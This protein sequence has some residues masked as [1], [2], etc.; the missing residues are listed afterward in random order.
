MNTVPQGSKGLVSIQAYDI[1][2]HSD[3]KV[4]RYVTIVEFIPVPNWL[5]SGTAPA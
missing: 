4:Q 2:S 3:P 1:F 5:L